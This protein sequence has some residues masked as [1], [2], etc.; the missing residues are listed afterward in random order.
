MERCY[1]VAERDQ[2]RCADAFGAPVGVR[3]LGDLEPARGT[4]FAPNV[5]HEQGAHERWHHHQAGPG[6]PPRR[7]GRPETALS[8]TEQGTSG[9][10][11]LELRATVVGKGYERPT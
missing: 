9:A 2:R 8:R 4:T 7:A 5:Q 11:M 10:A 6:Q 3:H 1:A